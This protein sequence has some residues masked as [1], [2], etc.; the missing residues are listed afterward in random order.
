[1]SRISG[2][3]II[4]GELRPEAASEKKIVGV[5]WLLGTA[6]LCLTPIFFG[7][8]ASSAGLVD[9]QPYGLHLRTLLP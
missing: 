3:G 5:S 6:Q 2:L 8:I 7:K 1:M 9:D 4:S